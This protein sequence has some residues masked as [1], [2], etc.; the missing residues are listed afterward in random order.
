MYSVKLTEQI[1]RKG[2]IYS[3]NEGNAKYW[4]KPTAKYVGL[5]LVIYLCEI[6]AIEMLKNFLVLSSL[7]GML[8]NA[9]SL[10]M[11]HPPSL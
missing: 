1:P 10:A 7:S 3:I 5:N 9:S 8:T 11:V 2:K 4:D 6:L